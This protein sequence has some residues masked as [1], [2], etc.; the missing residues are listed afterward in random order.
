[1]PYLL[2]YSIKSYS[3]CWNKC[4]LKYFLLQF[5][6]GFSIMLIL[7][8]TRDTLLIVEI[9]KR[10]SKCLNYHKFLCKW[11]RLVA[12]YNYCHVNT[13][14]IGFCCYKIKKL[15]K[16]KISAYLGFLICILLYLYSSFSVMYALTMYVILELQLL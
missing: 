11:T 3:D 13:D 1:M 16:K 4:T 14:F 8:I 6:L 5:E 7:C 15:I 12:Q 10:C 9:L 2:P